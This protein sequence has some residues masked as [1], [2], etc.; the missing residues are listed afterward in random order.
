MR[1]LKN[2]H[3]AILECFDRETELDSIKNEL[4]EIICEHTG[5]KSVGIRFKVEHDFPYLSS[6]GIP[7]ALVRPDNSLLCKDASGEIIRDDKNNT[8]LSCTCGRVIMGEKNS[9]SRLFT[10]F[11]SF[12][13]NN[14]QTLTEED[15]SEPEEECSLCRMYGY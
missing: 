12:W 15:I 11:G 1:D 9:D 14:I 13:S 10:K 5:V 2:L 6:K 4:I 8:L 3:S 7:D